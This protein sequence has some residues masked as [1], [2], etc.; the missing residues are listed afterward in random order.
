MQ[1]N[2][3]IGGIRVSML[4]GGS[5]EPHQIVWVAVPDADRGEGKAK[6]ALKA[7][8]NDADEEK[9]RLKVELVR[10]ERSTDLGL[11][12]KMF[13]GL[14]FTSDPKDAKINPDRTWMTRIGKWKP[15]PKA[16][17]TKS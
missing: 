8:I 10:G 7:V 4:L 16:K 5:G 17:P 2:Y 3:D 1:Q 12:R 13:E 11:L 14:G 6:E 9:V 15:E